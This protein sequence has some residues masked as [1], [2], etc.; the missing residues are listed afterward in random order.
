MATVGTDPE[1]RQF[2]DHLTQFLEDVVKRSPV[3]R[4]RAQVLLERLKQGQTRS[5]PGTVEEGPN[6]LEIAIE[7]VDGTIA[8]DT[9]D[10]R[11]LAAATILQACVGNPKLAGEVFGSVVTV[12]R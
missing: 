3:G 11:L 2:V 6:M 5:L 8:A 7:Y 4:S 12:E 10:A 9:D 1:S